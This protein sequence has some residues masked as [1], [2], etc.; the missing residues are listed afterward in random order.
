LVISMRT[1]PPVLMFRLAVDVL[2]PAIVVG[3]AGRESPEQRVAVSI[4]PITV[5]I[6]AITV[7][8][9]RRGQSIQ[10]SHTRIHYI[11]V[12]ILL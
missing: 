11:Y 1:E 7:Q 3:N 8:V 10:I 4:L 5:S 2:Y 12:L 9:A 6:L